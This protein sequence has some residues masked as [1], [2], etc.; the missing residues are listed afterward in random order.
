M[1]M[2]KKENNEKAKEVRLLKPKNDF[3]FQSLFNQNNER[4]TKAFVQA[5]LSEKISSIVINNDKELFRENP[6]EKLGILDL[7]VDVN[8]NEKIDVEIQLIE[9]ED[10]VQ[11]LLFYLTRMYEQQVKRGQDYSE[12]KRVV[13][14]AII[15]YKLDLTKDIKEMET[16]W[17][18]ME[19]K[20]KY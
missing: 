9:R 8:D 4:I 3:V 15:D 13:L 16:V 19:K 10:F 20:A 7:Q 17:I 18:L 14:I 11:R 2:A 1:S 5:L 12:V 6:E